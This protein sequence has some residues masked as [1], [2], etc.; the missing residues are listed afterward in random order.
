MLAECSAR[1]LGYPVVGR[2]IIQEAAQR[3]GV[4]EEAVGQ[5]ME[6]TPSLWGRRSL[7]RKLYVTAVQAALAERIVDGNLVYHGL[8]GQMLLRGLP[9]VLRL[10]LI[11]PMEVRIASLMESDAM[12]HSA[13]QKYIRETDDARPVG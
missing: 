2:E 10:R 4:S 11:A 3:L 7:A 5:G 12:E 13:A 6:H 8:A 9:A 1:R